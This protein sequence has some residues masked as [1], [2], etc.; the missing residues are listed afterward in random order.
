MIRASTRGRGVEYAIRD[1][2]VKA[3]QVRRSGKKL[4]QLNIGDP[5]PYGFDTP[6]HIKQSLIRATESGLNYYSASEGVRELREA[7]AEKE[8]RVNGASIEPEDVV[9][10]SGISEAIMF[11]MG[12]I[13]NAGDEVLMPGPSYPPYITYAKFFGGK[14][15]T[16]RT[17]EEK[18]WAPDLLDLESRINN[19]TRLIV[20]I[21][22]S[23]PTGSVYSSQD[24]MKILEL[25][26][27]NDLPVAADEIYDRII[28]DGKFSSVSSLAKDVPLIG[29]N[30]FSKSHMMTGWRLGYMYVQDHAGKLADVWDAVQRM[31]R[32]RLCAATP[33]QI[34]GVEALRG[35]QDHVQKMVT[36][37][38]KRRD[39]SWKR[40]NDIPGLHTAKPPGAFYLFPKITLG[41]NWKTDEEFV[42]DLLKE[43]GVV[44]VNGSGFDPE[45]G[46][47]HFRAVFLPPEEMLSEALSA[48][49]DF[50]KRHTQ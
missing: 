10:T 13:V 48:I 41:A 38:R 43:T 29:L 5:V 7:I 11:V 44:V 1:I 46:K 14:A 19:R 31:S 23:N 9:V 12:A 20:I 45:Y 18:N 50:M 24:I 6:S 16:Y 2:M 30:G 32:V 21:N 3:E 49:E 35:P 36:E 8:N 37:L 28:Y 15:V 22:P 26:A 47:D 4:L 27:S 17:I 34:A 39:Y 40:M 42:V 25:A 33:T